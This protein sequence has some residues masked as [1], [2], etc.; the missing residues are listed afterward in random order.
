MKRLSATTNSFLAC[1]KCTEIIGG[2]RSRVGVKLH[3]NTAGGLAPDGHV[4]ENFRVRHFGR[5]SGELKVTYWRRRRL[6]LS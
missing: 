6:Q 2:E 1:A 4:K 5:L 3:N